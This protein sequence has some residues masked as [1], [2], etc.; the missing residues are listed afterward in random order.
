MRI[1][2]AQLLS[3]PAVVGLGA[4][5]A[6]LAT[7]A[8]FLS[9]SEAMLRAQ[10]VTAF[11]SYTVAPAIAAQK[12][13]ANDV[14]PVPFAAGE[15]F[16]LGG[17]YRNKAVASSVRPASWGGAVAVGDEI[18][19]SGASGQRVYEVIAITELP[20]EGVTHIA[21]GAVPNGLLLVTAIRKGS[22]PDQH[23]RFVIDSNGGGIPG[24]GIT[25]PSTL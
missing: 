8:L 25:A 19:L 24:Q 10:F 14:R 2:S 18:T 9:T 1:S 16:W 13:A 7:G 20:I 15:D 21:H 11:D 6:L 5:S 3:R 4:V 12:T 22:N 23:I 17:A